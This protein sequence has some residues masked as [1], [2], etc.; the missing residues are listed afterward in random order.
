M[1]DRILFS[2]FALSTLASGITNVAVTLNLLPGAGVKFPAL[3]ANQYFMATLFNTAG[4]KEV[5]KCTARSTD[6]L[7]IVR[8]QEGT[9]GVAWITG[10]GI[11]GGFLTA[12]VADQFSQKRDLDY[13][14]AGGTGNAIT[15]TPD[16]ALTGYV[17]TKKIRFSVTAANTAAV[18]VNVSAIGARGLKR[19]TGADL[20][21]GDLFVG[22]IVEAYD[23]GTEYRIMSDLP[24]GADVLTMSAKSLWLAEGA[25]V[26]SASACNIWT[27]D[28]N[29]VHVTGT[30]T[31]DGWGTAPQAGAWKRVIF[32]GAAILT[33][34][35]T[36]NDLPGGTS[37]TTVAK[38]SCI[39]YARSTSSYQ[40]FDYTKSDGTT[41]QKPTLGT[42][43]ATTSGTAVNF[44]GIPSWVTEIIIGLAG[45]STN[46]TSLPIIQLGDSGGIEI[47]GYLGATANLQDSTAITA[48]NSTDGF[49]IINGSGAAVRHGRITLN[50]I[51][52][53]TNTWVCSGLIAFSSGGAIIVTGGS[54][55]LS[56]ILD[57]VRLTTQNGTDTFDAGGVNIRYS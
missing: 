20:R 16:P 36:T 33:Y 15:L 14:T 10:D 37:I 11:V 2:N 23:N 26:A 9:A 5:I 8:G 46:G 44:T 54:K 41:L 43:A 12:G 24:V 19:I 52:P 48:L 18:T 7:T 25:T 6:Q 34:N 38:D 1:T 57:R 17:A 45:V 47:T 35:A 49:S 30:T 4:V 53:A 50:L 39:V 13:L 27:T 56:A 31:I 32:D 55:S 28:G 40:I 29:T 21:V 42:Y 51:N 3:S 22:Q